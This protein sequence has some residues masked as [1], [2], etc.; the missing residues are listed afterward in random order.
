MMA[1]SLLIGW[2][3]M[4]D[5]TMPDEDD[6]RIE[7]DSSTEPI[8]TAGD[9][10]APKA[11]ESARNGAAP[12]SDST[13]DAPA[14]SA[15]SPSDAVWPDLRALWERKLSA[16]GSRLI[17][18]VEIENFKGIGRPMRVDLRPVTLLFGNNS[19]GKSTVLHALCYAHEI[20]SH[21]N[22]DAH[23]TEL[24]GDRID[25][26]GF[27]N[28]VHAHDPARTVRLR[29]DLNLEGWNPPKLA[30]K[31]A[32]NYYEF[33]PK[34]AI[35]D[36]VLQVTSGW[37]ELQ[38]ELRDAQPLLVS[39]EVGVNETLVGCI[40][41]RRQE[42]VVLEFNPAHPLLSNRQA[43]AITHEAERTDDA[44]QA[45]T[46]PD[47][48]RTTYRSTDDARR[49]SRVAVFGLT[50]ALPRWSEPL[51]LDE[52][53]LDDTGSDED[54]SAV[55]RARVTALFAGIGQSLRDDLTRLRYIG[56]VRDLHPRTRTASPP[57]A[58]ERQ[59]AAVAADF[60]HGRA[61]A[62][63][64][65][66]SRLASWADGSAAWARLHDAPGRG[67]I[68]D[69]N[70]WLA[71]RDRLDT[72]YALRARSLVTVQEDDGQLVPTLREY[73]R[74]RDQF[75]NA[76][77]SVDLDRW[78]RKQADEIITG[79]KNE[80]DLATRTCREIREH[81]ARIAGADYFDAEVQEAGQGV[82]M[83]DRYL[84]YLRESGSADTIVARIKTPD[85]DG[86]HGPLGWGKEDTRSLAR[87]V[88]RTDS[89]KE[90]RDEIRKLKIQDDECRDE[91]RK[92]QAESDEYGD[93]IRKYE[94]EYDDATTR[95]SRK[96]C[97]ILRELL[98]NL[99]NMR[100]NT[101][102]MLKNKEEIRDNIRKLLD[103]YADGVNVEKVEARIETPSIEGLYARVVRVQREYPR[104]AELVT[105][106]QQ[107]QFTSMEVNELAAALAADAPQRELQLVT[108][109]TGLPVRPA[110]VGVGISQI[111][112]VV[113]AA[114]DPDRA[115]ITAI[116]Q[117]EI[118]LHP[119][120]QV[121]VGDLFAHQ[122]DK[123]GSFL[124]ETHSE[125]LLLRFM[126]RMRQTCDGTLRE[127]TPKVRPED[128]AVYF[129]E[130]DPDGE[131]TLIREMPLNERGEL[132]EAWPGG[133]FEE[134]LREI[135]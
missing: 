119:R 73:H 124:I 5:K 86:I 100:E 81:L 49:L 115:G 59:M 63:G 93:E 41:T 9:A 109:K 67:L 120:V 8:E 111:L 128:I 58:P 25:L 131:Q 133:F 66:S 132:V 94:V 19:A 43:D 6:R 24:G 48:A 82:E 87:I 121:E 12:K 116:E 7:A 89:R 29:F 102:A 50:S 34:E 117:P 127:G 62:S 4:T 18:A 130:I 110:D 74:L 44:P 36:L 68:D 91:M 14:P 97:Q 96:E 27:H 103:H 60:I 106:T 79:V 123:G 92:L 35:D 54:A 99:T 32:P 80:I 13:S 46:P 88:A 70:D 15:T 47:R 22:V 45:N 105:K 72:G 84:R 23:T 101:T 52:R 71:G 125:H 134:D 113:V 2:N 76:A 28:F 39:Y 56:P 95:R 37:V 42:G 20:L 21:G 107:R 30:E 64:S 122:L 31:L 33:E 40:R 135:F 17:I 3:E 126:K 53:E 129:V 61:A 69:V 78:V 75:G 85:Q 65:Q 114:L 38:V 1:R 83:V 112:P 51:L 10:P 98:E 11:A 55:F 118:H 108:V 90:H 57:P 16:A 77:G 104:L 26:G